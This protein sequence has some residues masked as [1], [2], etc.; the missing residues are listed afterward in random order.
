MQ[1]K[2]SLLFVWLWLVSLGFVI[3]FCNL[4][5]LTHF[6]KT[7]RCSLKC[8]SKMFWIRDV[9]TTLLYYLSFK[10][11]SASVGEELMLLGNQKRFP[12]CA[13]HWISSAYSS[14]WTSRLKSVFNLPH[15]VTTQL[16]PWNM[17]TMTFGMLSIVFLKEVR[18][19]FR[20][21]CMVNMLDPKL[22]VSLQQ[23]RDR[24]VTCPKCAPSFALWQPE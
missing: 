17:W 1:F 16:C 3:L 8:K 24:L 21:Y 13:R 15:T 7:W 14:S 20:R 9:F 5:S 19:K 22:N 18:P 6:V 12:I 11:L 23:P 10:Q 2:R 4:P